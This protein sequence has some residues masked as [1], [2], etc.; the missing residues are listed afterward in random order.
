MPDLPEATV[1]CSG[2]NQ[3]VLASDDHA[4]DFGDRRSG[5]T[6]MTLVPL[7]VVFAF[8]KES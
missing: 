1:D 6:N 5:S 3:G 4:E 8:S 7:L 2:V